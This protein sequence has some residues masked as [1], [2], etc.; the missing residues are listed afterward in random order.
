MPAAAMA[1]MRLTAARADNESGRKRIAI[2]RETRVTNR[3]ALT[4]SGD[5]SDIESLVDILALDRL[6]TKKEQRN[7]HGDDKEE[8]QD[9]QR[10]CAGC[11]GA[12]G[13]RAGNV[14]SCDK[15]G[16][17]Q[18]DAGC[19][20]GEEDDGGVAGCQHGCGGEREVLLSVRMRS[21]GGMVVWGRGEDAMSA[22]G[23]YTDAGSRQ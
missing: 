20:E 23:L 14:A 19:A 17:G 8:T 4:S 15:V 21:E 7:S 1:K 10:R 13:I 16:K 2:S 11:E 3:P 6:E 22:P 12:E 9:G 5:G 18:G